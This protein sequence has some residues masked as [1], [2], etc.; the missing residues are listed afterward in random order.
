MSA[1]VFNPRTIEPFKKLGLTSD[2]WKL[3]IDFLIATWIALGALITLT[4]I[5]WYCMRKKYLLVTTFYEKIVEFFI[6]LCTNGLGSFHVSYF[7]F[8]T[9]LFLFTSFCCF[10]GIIPFIEEATSNVN[11]T[12]AIALCSFCYV[13]RQKIKLHGIKGFLRE[14]IE[15]FPIMAPM[16][17][18]GEGSK[19]ASMTFRLFGNII[20]GGIIV[21][22]LFDFLRMGQTYLTVFIFSLLA[23]HAALR[24]AAR[25]EISWLQLIYNGVSKLLNIVFVL[26][27][28]LQVIFGIGEGILQAF[29]L[30]ILT[31]TFLALAMQS[32]DSSHQTGGHK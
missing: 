28:G 27:C 3:D 20:G 8:A 15:P 18:V 7:C 14:F 31:I 22:M 32:D 4:L 24:I 2:F 6:D 12:L 9:S 16:H 10:V 23:V 11:T 19:I 25:Y 17:L 1:D 13:Q 30:T 21:H 5:S 26:V 29:V